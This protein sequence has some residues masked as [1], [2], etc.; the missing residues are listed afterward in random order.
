[1]K[2]TDKQIIAARKVIAEEKKERIEIM[3]QTGFPQ[4]HVYGLI[5]KMADTLLS[6]EKSKK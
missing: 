3:K 4:G 5:E 6:N 2:F 1:M